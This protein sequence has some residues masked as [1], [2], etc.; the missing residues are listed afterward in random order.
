[1][2]FPNAYKGVR[3]I[4]LAQILAVIAAIPSLAI[5]VIPQV[6]AANP[7][8]PAFLGAAVLVAA[9]VLLLV[10]GGIL[11]IVGV[12]RAAKDEPAFR[13]ALIALVVGGIARI[14]RYAFSTNQLVSDIFNYVSMATQILSSYYICTGVINLGDRLADADVSARGKKVRTL[15]LVL[16]LVSAALNRLAVLFR[17]SASML[18]VLA[19]VAIVSSLVSIVAY[20]LYLGFLGRAK[21]MLQ[22]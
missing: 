20:F 3:K 16:W 11:N 9:A 18:T 14:V 1:M 17:G 2:R 19:A 22:F 8:N 4:Y 15:L 5:T 13:N 10:I 6:S 7:E 12:N 21:K